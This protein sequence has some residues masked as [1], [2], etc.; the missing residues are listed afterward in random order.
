MRKRRN[1]PTVPCDFYEDTENKDKIIK[2]KIRSTPTFVMFDSDGN[3]S[4]RFS[5]IAKSRIMQPNID[6]IISN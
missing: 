2:Y 1:I 5:G 6:A 4:S 3:E